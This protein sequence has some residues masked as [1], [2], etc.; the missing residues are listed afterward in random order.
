ME[1]PPRRVS[2]H[3]RFPNLDQEDQHRQ[4]KQFADTNDGTLFF[5]WLRFFCDRLAP[6]DVK[7]F[8][9]FGSLEE[10]SYL[11][12]RLLSIVT[13]YD[14]YDP[15]SIWFSQRM[16]YYACFVVKGYALAVIRLLLREGIHNEL[17]TTREVCKQNLPFWWSMH[18]VQCQAFLVY[19]SSSEGKSDAFVRLNAIRCMTNSMVQ[20][21]VC[22]A[23]FQDVKGLSYICHMLQVWTTTE[24]FQL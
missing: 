5:R 19:F 13:A 24:G 6:L 3:C 18:L 7:S 15:G 1:Q 2:E 11:C 17:L 21:G 22:R 23:S 8:K 9:G 16:H 4:L 14:Q 20:S 12:Q 10:R